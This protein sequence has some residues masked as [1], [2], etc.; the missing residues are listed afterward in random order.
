[1]QRGGGQ[2]I[3]LCFVLLL[4]LLPLLVGAGDFKPVTLSPLVDLSGTWK[5]QTGD[6]LQWALPNYDDSSWTSLQVPKPWGRQQYK[7]YSGLAW[8]RLTF[9]VPQN[10][11]ALP[12]GISVGYVDSSYQL[13]AGGIRLGGVGN[14]PPNP[15]L[16]YDRRK[17]YYL[18]ESAVDA[19]GKVVIAVRVWKDP[20]MNATLGGFYQGETRVGYF[21]ALVREDILSQVPALL[22]SV[23]FLLVGLY[24]IHLYRSRREL[25]EYLWFGAMASFNAAV[26]TFLTSQWKYE[27]SNQFVLLKELES[28]AAMTSPAVFIQFLWPMLGR[29]IT[30][31]LRYYQFFNI[32]IAL[33]ATL[34]PGIALNVRLLPFWQAGL[35]VGVLLCLHLIF[36]E[37]RRGESDARTIAI[38]IL[39]FVAAAFNDVA[40]DR[41][42]ISSIR[43][44]PYGFAVFLLSMAISLANRFTRVHAEVSQLRM[45]LED[46]VRQR[47]QELSV[48][49][50]ELTDANLKLAERSRELAEASIAKSQFLANMSHELR[51][52]LNAI[53]GYSEILLEEA[54]DSGNDALV[55]DL[56]KI[57]VA[58][59]HL[60]GLINDILDLSKIEA[61]RMDL[62]LEPFNIEAMLED[63]TS[64]IAP[65]V[66]KN[67]NHFQ[68]NCPPAIG[69]MRADVKRVRQVLLNLLSNACKFT[70][71]G[72]ITLDVSRLEAGNNGNSIQFRVM[73]TGIGMTE[74]QI[75]KLF[76]A[77]SQADA[78]ITR[79][80]GGTGL[81]L[82]ISKR[83]CQMM[84]GDLT[85]ESKYGSGSTFLAQLPVEVAEIRAE[86]ASFGD[87]R[88]ETPAL[89]L[90]N[91]RGIVL[92]IDD[93][94][95]ARDLMVRV[96]SREGY[97]VVTA[98]GGEEGLRLAHDLHPSVITLDVLMPGL[99][100]WDVLKELKGNPRLAEIPVIMITMEEDRNKGVSLGAADYISKPIKREE[101]LSILG[102][103][104]RN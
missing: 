25:K 99:D 33:L 87:T 28:L 5:F 24:H 70:E 104:V 86:I 65:L 53:I 50:T 14:L 35:V 82:V 30:R 61:G 19:S 74:Q 22:L 84:G 72:K 42:W 90:T 29:P 12:L 69:S 88:I 1:M 7:G 67:E 49:S 98:W 47:T 51:T 41:N 64:T 38:G 101:L 4:L 95:A 11:A 78:S 76:F 66:E 6:N 20:S 62:Y 57:Q 34:T 52:P 32:G 9:Y 94:R 73:D 10:R 17:A 55:P 89:G 96:I 31:K 8:Y 85:V 2:T 13:F 83:F 45:D 92:V 91:G 54:Q 27:I 26:Y 80:Y 75:E 56:K 63:M 46:R 60:L 3:G 59:K 68:V 37:A 102:K 21:D 97:R 16:E 43:L 93:D 103:Y 39:F 18:P 23:L 100:G 77:F 79:K 58:G 40:L 44:V 48:R 15:R 81:G 71:R 36:Q